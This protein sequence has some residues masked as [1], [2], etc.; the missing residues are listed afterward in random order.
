MGCPHTEWTEIIKTG[1][2]DTKTGVGDIE[3]GVVLI[4]KLCGSY[5]GT[6]KVLKVCLRSIKH[7]QTPLATG[8]SVGDR[9]MTPPT[10]S[11]LTHAYRTVCPF[12]SSLN[13]V[14]LSRGIASEI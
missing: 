4:R 12:K 8:I 10:P 5:S 1:E 14:T 11:V 6:L 7:Q 9:P 2:G 3:G 13:A